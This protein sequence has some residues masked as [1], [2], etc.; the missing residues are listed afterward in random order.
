MLFYIAD[1]LEQ[2]HEEYSSGA[3]ELSE[4]GQFEV[5]LVLLQCGVPFEVRNAT[6]QH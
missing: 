1:I 2:G 4:C 3:H 5:K 6:T